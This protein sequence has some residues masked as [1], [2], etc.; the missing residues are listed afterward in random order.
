M[1][2]PRSIDSILGF[3]PP[4][5]GEMAPRMVGLEEQFEAEFQAQRAN[6][7][8]LRAE[9]HALRDAVAPSR[10]ENTALRGVIETRR[11]AIQARPPRRLELPVQRPV[12]ERIFTGSLGATRVAPYWWASSW[13]SISGD[14][15]GAASGEESGILNISAP[16]SIGSQNSVS[17]RAW[18]GTYFQP[19]TE[20]G[21]LVVSSNPIIVYDYGD[22]CFDDGCSTYGWIGLF[23]QE[24]DSHGVPSGAPIQQNNYLWSDASWWNGIGD[25]TGAGVEPLSAVLPVNNEH[26][27]GLFVWCG[28]T[29]NSAGWGGYFYSIGWGTMAVIVPSITWHLY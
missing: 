3:T 16:E 25:N 20:Q 9:H 15:F 13:K 14:G 23:V 29:T 21:L 10:S 24:Y 28:L 18:V 7:D 1:N 19:P 22:T 6:Y 26:S 27:Y 5:A 2:Q 11:A 8:A 12:Q 17:A 4:P